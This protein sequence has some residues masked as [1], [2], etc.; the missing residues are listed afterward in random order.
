MKRAAIAV[1]LLA[2]T[3]AGPAEAQVRRLPERVAVLPA[4]ERIGCYWYRQREYCSRYCY[5]EINGKRYCRER[6][7]DAWS[8]APVVEEY[9]PMAPMK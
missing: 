5:W 2:A 3:A 7:R 9:Y 8:Q 4:G 1:V 6:E